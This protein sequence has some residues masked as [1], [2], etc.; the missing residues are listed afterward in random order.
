M[1]LNVE[2]REYYNLEAVMQGWDEQYEKEI[3]I[4]NNLIKTALIEHN[5]KKLLNFEG[6]ANLVLKIV[7]CMSRA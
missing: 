4:N 2:D 5:T 7:R 1:E 6:S 3:E